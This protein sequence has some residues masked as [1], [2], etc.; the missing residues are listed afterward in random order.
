MLLTVISRP[1]RFRGSRIEPLCSPACRK[2][3]LILGKQGC[4]LGLYH[5]WWKSKTQIHLGQHQSWPNP[6]RILKDHH[7]HRH[8][9]YFILTSFKRQRALYKPFMAPCSHLGWCDVKQSY[10]QSI[11]ELTWL[12]QKYLKYS[13]SIFRLGQVAG[14]TSFFMP[15]DFEYSCH[16]HG[17]IC[18]NDVI[19]HH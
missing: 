14:T 12:S 11:I 13:R 18:Y 19:V 2:R 15:L 9:L 3:R 7:H 6:A 10:N 16:T 17:A 1:L 4:L 5:Q 8:Q